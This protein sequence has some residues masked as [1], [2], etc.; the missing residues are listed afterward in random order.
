MKINFLRITQIV[1]AA[2]LLLIF[3]TTS[4]AQEII[5]FSGD[6]LIKEHNLSTK[7]KL[8]VKNPY[9]RRVEM[10]KE[11]GGMIFICP[12]DARGKVWML[13]PVKKQYKILSWPQTHKDPVSAWT[14]MQYDM[15]GSF[16]GEETLN[17]HACAI[18]EYKYP[19]KDKIALTLWL[20]D[21]LHFAIK[22]VADAKSI[23]KKNAPP[24]IIKGTFQVLNI[25]RKDLDNMLFEIPSDYTETK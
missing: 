20:A 25:K 16:A 9:I 10:S 1:F 11:N 2:A 22:R 5:S 18:Y 23:V 12:K 24:K 3:V 7:A 21:D 15:A 8:Y 4:S 14:D 6:I 13:D 17:G 19:D